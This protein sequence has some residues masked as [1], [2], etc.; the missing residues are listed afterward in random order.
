MR[1]NVRSETRST[2]DYE[3]VVGGKLQSR[4]GPHLFSPTP[5]GRFIS[6]RAAV[7]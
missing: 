6:A 4:G 1:L 3:D 7:V 5:G 2:E